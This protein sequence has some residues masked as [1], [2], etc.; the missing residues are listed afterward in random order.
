V[1]PLNGTFNKDSLLRLVE[2]N[3]GDSVVEKFFV[4]NHLSRSVSSLTSETKKM[5]LLNSKF[6]ELTGSTIEGVQV[7]TANSHAK[8]GVLHVVS[9][10]LPYQKSIYEALCD[11]PD[12][13]LTGEALRK[14]DEDWFDGDASVSSGMVEGVPVYVDSVVIERNRLLDR[15]GYLQRED[16]LYWTVVPSAAGWQKAWDEASQYFVY[17]EDVLKRDSLQHYWTT[18]ALMDDAIYN[19]TDQKSTEDSLI[20]V[21]YN[22]LRPEYH[23][24]YKPFAEGGI[25]SNAQP[26]QCSNGIVY[27]TQEWP[28]TPEQTYF[29]ELWS[30]GEYTSLITAEQQVVYS[31]QK[32][33]GDSISEGGYLDILGTTAT[34]N[35]E[36]TFRINNTLSGSYDIC[37]IVLPKSVANQV[38]PDLKP[39]KFRA[40][41]NYVDEKGNA[42]THDCGGKQFQNNPEKV[43]TIVLA[44]GFHFPACNY[45]QN[46]IKVSVRLQCS[47]TTR[48][49]SRFSREMLLDCI[50]LR[51]KR[52]QN[53]EN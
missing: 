50:Y 2:T 10:P 26:I 43:D 49:T 44:E 23:V 6:V 46:D 12:L 3:Q 39:N 25:L 30:E 1:A 20:S 38:N 29:K 8:N 32:A 40:V 11:L 9:Q 53:I 52:I 33:A 14:Y 47:I 45:G 19:M 18:S 7:T 27:K 34:A 35:W 41:I 4:L 37:A 36:L 24:F 22:R 13:S 48:E 5:L 31:I 17:A 42:K 21:P 16:S 28:F 15:L 51:P